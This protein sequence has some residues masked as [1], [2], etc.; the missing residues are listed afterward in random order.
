MGSSG[1]MT[2]VLQQLESHAH[3]GQWGSGQARRDGHLCPQPLR[4]A[5]GT[6]ACENRT[7]QEGASRAELR[8]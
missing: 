3:L 2:L 6:R 8:L 4:A 7:E 1:A 5:G